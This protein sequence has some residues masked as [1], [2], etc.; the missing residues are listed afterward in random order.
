MAIIFCAAMASFALWMTYS[1]RNAS[2]AGQFNFAVP[3]IALKKFSKCGWWIFLVNV[4]GM[5]YCSERR[6]FAHVHFVG[7]GHGGGGAGA[8]IIFRHELVPGLARGPR[9]KAW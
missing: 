8:Q 6:G 5:S 1:L 9:G 7:V 4:T 2:S 3:R